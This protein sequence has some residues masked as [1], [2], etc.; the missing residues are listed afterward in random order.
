MSVSAATVRK[1]FAPPE[2]A[3]RYGVSVSKVH[4][5]IASGELRATNL[6]TRPNGRPRWKIDESDLLAFENARANTPAPEPAPPRRQ[7]S[8]LE[9]TEFF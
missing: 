3:R 7:K 1:K 9:V 5:W 8:D 6:A 2:L 4:A